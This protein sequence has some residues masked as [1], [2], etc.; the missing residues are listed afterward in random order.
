VRDFLALPTSLQIAAQ[1]V[2]RAA[3]GVRRAVVPARLSSIRTRSA[4]SLGGNGTARG[5]LEGG[6][7]VSKERQL[8][9]Q[10]YIPHEYKTGSRTVRLAVL[11]GVLDADGWYSAEGKCYDLTLTSQTLIEDVK[12]VARSLGFAVIDG[13]PRKAESHERTNADGAH[14]RI[15]ICGDGIEEIPVRSARKMTERAR[16]GQARHGAAVHRHRAAG[17]RLFRLHARRAHQPPL[18][19]G[20]LRRHAQHR[21]YEEGH[22]VPH[23]RRR[24]GRRRRPARGA[25]ARRQPDSR[26]ARQRQDDAQRQ[27]VALRQVHRD[28]V[29]RRRLHQRRRD[30]GVP[31]REVA[32]RAGREGR[33][34]VPHLLPAD[35]GRVEGAQRQAPP[36]QGR[37]TTST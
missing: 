2:L 6:N 12:F 35:R 14:P 25:A 23:H 5:E 27:L 28:P 26:G 10:Q 36:R 4:T 33:A 3:A 30:L 34:H 13:V 24:Q 20:Q 16:A 7:D 19:A 32:H 15:T 8:S 1:G 31:A 18:R 22:P 29:Q 37:A 21:E 17:G 9:S 11:A